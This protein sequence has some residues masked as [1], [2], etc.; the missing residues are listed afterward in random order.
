MILRWQVLARRIGAVLLV[1]VVSYWIIVNIALRTGALT[2]LIDHDSDDIQF[3]D[4]DGAWS[5]WPGHVRAERLVMRLQD[6]RIAFELDIRDARFDVSLLELTKRTFHAWH[7]RA[8]DVRFRLL[9]KVVDPTQ[10]E[11]RIA[12]FPRIAGVSDPPL[13]HPKPSS[14]PV[15]V[16]AWTV[17]LDEVDV[18]VT[19]LWLMEYRFLG[20]ARAKGG[21]RLQPKRRVSISPSNL[22]VTSGRVSIGASDEVLSK[23]SGRVNCAVQL[24]DPGSVEGTEVLRFVSA[25]AQLRMNVSSLRL[26]NLYVRPSTLHLLEGSGGLNVDA[27]LERGVLK[28]IVLPTTPRRR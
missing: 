14:A 5:P 7:L 18:P 24:H 26:V 20:A 3:L 22:E 19:E 12:A 8:S 21:F 25:Q 27:A 17:A 16:N 2:A 4:V 13:M 10:N 15:S 28:P 1:V 11:K 6:S 9:H 23:I